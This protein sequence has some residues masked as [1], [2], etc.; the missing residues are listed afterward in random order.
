MADIKIGNSLTNDIFTTGLV[1]VD[2]QF[3]DSFAN[4]VKISNN[5]AK[6]IGTYYKNSYTITDDSEPSELQNVFGKAIKGIFCQIG[7]SKEA[8]FGFTENNDCF[9]RQKGT[10]EYR[11]S[12]NRDL[13]IYTNGNFNFNYY[14]NGQWNT[15]YDCILFGMGNSVVNAYFS[16]V[17][18]TELETQGKNIDYIFSNDIIKKEKT[19]NSGASYTRID[20]TSEP[21]MIRLKNFYNNDED[22]VT[23]NITDTDFI[24]SKYSNE[25]LDDSWNFSVPKA[26]EIFR[27]NGAL[28]FVSSQNNQVILNTIKKGISTTTTINLQT[29]NSL[30]KNTIYE[31]T[32]DNI[33]ITYTTGIFQYG[34]TGADIYDRNSIILGNKRHHLDEETPYYSESFNRIRITDG[35]WGSV[36]N[37]ITVEN[38]QTTKHISSRRDLI[39]YFC[40]FVIEGTN[41]S[42]SSSSI[43]TSYASQVYIVIN[44]ITT[45]HIN[46]KFSGGVN[47]FKACFVESESSTNK[48]YD[49][50]AS[51]Y[52]TLRYSASTP[53]GSRI[54]S[55]FIIEAVRYEGNSLIVSCS[56]Y[57]DY[58]F[59]INM[60]NLRFTWQIIPQ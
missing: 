47:A 48:T 7:N 58:G 49:Y 10:K 53:T 13:S 42:V 40:A 50:D 30:E 14:K 26:I 45:E 31:E 55:A 6:A 54:D 20:T 21:N 23:L 44:G 18:L 2:K 41:I 22:G 39:K 60:T 3:N 12:V 9:I 38:T 24:I 33:L 52:I 19:F 4:C 46:K 51:G 27:T 57:D 32:D 34:S 36:K 8:E 11:I 16:R 29:L 17:Q 28:Q 5:I 43:N 35:L 37:E 1:P 59:S 56:N 15:S 25:I